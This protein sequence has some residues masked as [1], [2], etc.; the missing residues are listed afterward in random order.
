[1]SKGYVYILRCSDG[2]YYVGSTKWVEARLYQHETGEGAEYTKRR[3]PVELVYVEEY[4]RI[5]EAFG[6]EKQLQRWSH[7]KRQ[8][9]IEGKW[10]TLSVLSRGRDRDR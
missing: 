9:L 2:T 1:M 7:A 4:D 6:R 3:R 10:A 5:D 8:A